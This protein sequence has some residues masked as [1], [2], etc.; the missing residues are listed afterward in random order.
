MEKKCWIVV[1]TDNDII[2][3]IWGSEGVFAMKKERS[4]FIDLMECLA[5]M[6]VVAYHGAL[7]PY[8]H[9]DTGGGME[10]LNYYLRTISA[11]CVPLFF[12]AN[13]YLLFG[14]T[15]DLKKHVKK[16]LRLVFLAFF[17]GGVT[18]LFLQLVEGGPVSLGTLF[19]G[20]WNW[21]QGKINHLW[22]LGALVC[23]YVFFPLLKHV[24]DTN[25]KYFLYF[26]IVSA[27]FTFGNTLLNHLGTIGLRVL[28]KA[29]YWTE[30]NFFNIFNPF[31]GIR[32][33]AF[34]YFCVGGL[35]Y[36]YRE[37]IEAIS[38]RKR[39]IVSVIGILLS[40]AGLWGLGIF[41][42]GVT[43]SLWDVVWYGYDTVFTLANV[44]FIYLL[45]LNWKCD[46]FVIRMVSCNTL[47]IFFLHEF[48][49]PVT[50]TYLRGIPF[51]QNIPATILYAL[52]VIGICTVVSAVM[53]KIPV[54]SRLV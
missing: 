50:R 17:W 31:R 36:H 33:Y 2:E 32:G 24:F 45:C 42:S 46:V 16:T 15:L 43:G 54:V 38:V 27:I 35:A 21:E 5:I 20:V 23:I 6:L 51:L 40:C 30:F 1:S 48:I 37:R 53:K 41:Y 13:G 47:G 18:L 39:N 52:G 11:T 4:A 19:S 29:G 8:D 34:V 3:M 49:V 25:K 14:K 22:Y 44:V 26:L 7:Y 10:Y 12:F 9:H 28:G